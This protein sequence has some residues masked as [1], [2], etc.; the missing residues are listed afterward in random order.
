MLRKRLF[1]LAGKLAFSIL[2]LWFVLR[3]VDVNRVVDRLRTA[4]I[5][6][7]LPVLLL[8]PCSVLLSAWRWRILGLGL[9]G[10]G[11]AVRYTW[12]GLFFGAILPGV[13]GGDVAK[14]VSLAAKTTR[15]RNPRIALSIAMDKAVGFWVLLLNFNL[16]G[17]TLLAFQPHLLPGMRNALWA[18][19]GATTAGLAAAAAICHPRGASSL[20]GIAARLPT[21]MLRS[22]AGYALEALRSYN[23]QGRLLLQA[24]LISAA[25]HA[26]NAFSTWLVMRSLAIPASLGFAAVYYPL[27]SGLLALPVSMSGVGVRDIFSATM[28]TS[29]GLHPESGV[30]LSWLLLGLSIPNLLVGAAIQLWE[31]FRPGARE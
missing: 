26:L 1:L 4:D 30:A 3:N 9:I 19:I 6:W 20:S 17:L 28:F 7:I 15:A 12:I 24:A 21:K 31:I 2:L 13:V 11:E 10:F 5:R 23:G 8:G 22:A 29:F 16:A 25:I 27:L 14:G 18:G